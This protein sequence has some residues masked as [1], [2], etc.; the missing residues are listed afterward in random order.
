MMRALRFGKR[1]WSPRYYR[2]PVCS[3]NGLD[4]NAPNRARCG[5]VQGSSI[6]R[7]INGTG[8]DVQWKWAEGGSSDQSE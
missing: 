7:E 6:D 5:F 2:E 3:S 8:E 4:A 1:Y